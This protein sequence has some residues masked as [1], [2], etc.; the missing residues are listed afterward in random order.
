MSNGAPLPSPSPSRP[1]PA[2]GVVAG[3]A[4]AERVGSLQNDVDAPSPAASERPSV[5]SVVSLERECSSPSLAPSPAP[6]PHPP[7]LCGD[8]LPRPAPAPA[9]EPRA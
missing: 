6:A 8:A 1:R 9:L 7:R 2:A 5:P 4:S 3:G